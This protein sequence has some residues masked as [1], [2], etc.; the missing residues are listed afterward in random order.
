MNKEQNTIFSKKK[1]L[2]TG[3]PHIRKD[4][5]IIKVLTRFPRSYNKTV[6]SPSTE[7]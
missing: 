6:I 2:K 4:K 3:F 7:K 5:N 1:A